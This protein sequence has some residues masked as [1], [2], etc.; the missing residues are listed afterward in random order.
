MKSLTVGI[1]FGTSG[2]RAIVINKN[3][4]IQAEIKENYQKNPSYNSALMWQQT[5]YQLLSKIPLV[6]RQNLEVIAINGTSSTVL[7]CDRKGNPLDAPILYNDQR[8]KGVI[9]ELK[10]YVPLNHLAL[11]PTSSLAKLKWWTK[12]PIFKEADYFLHQADWLSFLLHGKLGISDYH[13]ALKL[14]YDVEKLCYPDWLINQTYYPL[15]PKI[16][17]PGQEIAPITSDVAQRF[18]IPKNCM[19]CAGTT[20]SIAAFLAS[21]ASQAGEAVT[22]LGST[23]VLKLLS[24]QKVDDYQAGIYSHR[25]GNLWLTGGASNTGGAVLKHFFNDEA[26]RTFSQEIDPNYPTDLDYYP[27]LKQGERFPYNDPNLL[28]K[29]DPKPQDSV[30]F[31]QGLL[32]GMAK[33]EALGYKRLRELGATALIH[34][35]TAGGG[36][37]NQ[38]WQQIRQRYLPVSVTISSQT[39]AAYG[40]ALLARNQLYSN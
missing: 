31:L 13:N 38:V 33:I 36:A 3:L 29:L 28:P 16:L 34:V 8:G 17:T 12:Q 1:D 20:D 14:G 4:E 40:T 15:L 23:L 32:E 2:A 24:E 27:L 35:Y 21:G 37:K 26:L 25:L 9:D 7:L 18:N 19:V 22:S 5:L 39:E 30:L 11:S 10:A 6:L